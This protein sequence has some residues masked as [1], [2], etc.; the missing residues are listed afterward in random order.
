MESHGEPSGA[1]RRI[2]WAG[3]LTAAGLLVQMAT[4]W[5]V[6]PL[7]FASFLVIGCPLLAAGIG[8]YVLSLI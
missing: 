2:R 3:I 6:H 7:A 8:L 1:A 4:F 5:V